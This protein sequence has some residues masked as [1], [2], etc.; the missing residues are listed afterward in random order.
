MNLVEKIALFADAAGKPTHAARQLPGGSLYDLAEAG[1]LIIV[2]RVEGKSIGFL[3][4][5]GVGYENVG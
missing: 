5:V 2:A 4:P 3:Q 1:K